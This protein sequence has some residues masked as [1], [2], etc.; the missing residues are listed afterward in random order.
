[1]V[2][3][4]SLDSNSKGQPWASWAQSD[5]LPYLQGM[6]TQ[7]HRRDRRRGAVLQTQA[8]AQPE[9]EQ[10]TAPAMLA[11]VE[12]LK[13]SALTA[14]ASDLGWGGEGGVSEVTALLARDACMVSTAI[15]HTAMAHR[16]SVLCTIKASS[17]ADTACQLGGACPARGQ[18]M[19]NRVQRV[20]HPPPPPSAFTYLPQPASSYQ[21]VIPHHK[22]SQKGVAGV[23]LTIQ[24][25]LATQLLEAYERWGRPILVFGSGDPGPAALFVDDNGKEYN[26]QSICH[27][28]DKVHR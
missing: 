15:G 1:V 12:Q 7:L 19:G 6:R 9:P 5:L 3:W 4:L 14:L 25:P 26:S 22:N 21:L 11:W 27:W 2:S 17:Y 24:D 13:M 10:T 23:S 20:A 28:W 8:L 16:G 18:C